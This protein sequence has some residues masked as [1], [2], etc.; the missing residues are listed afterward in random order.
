MPDTTHPSGEVSPDDCG[1]LIDFPRQD[2]SKPPPKYDNLP[3]QLTSFIGRE[4]EI[5]NLRKLLTTEARLVTLT[6][7]GGSGKTR[8]ALAVASDLVEGFEDGAWWVEL[9]SLS[10]QDLVAQAVASVLSVREVPGRSMSDALVEYLKEREVLLVLDNCEHLVASCAALCDTLL[11]AC[12]KLKILTTSREALRAPGEA[13]F[14]VPPLSLPDPHRPPDAEGLPGYEATRLF[15]ERARAAR[16]DFSLT[17]ENATAVAQ[18]CHRLDGIPLAIEL[19]AFRTRVLSV[20]QISKRLA[21]SFELL[22]GGSRTTMAH[23]MTLRATMDWSHAL[24]SE[25]ERRLF[26]RLSAFAGGCTLSAAEAICAE[27]LL[28]RE[29]ILDLLTQ[30]VDKS[31]VLVLAERDGE[32][33]YE[34]LETLRQYGR[35]KLEGSGEARG[36]RARHAAW[37]LA[38]AE[39]AEPHLRGRRQ[40]EWLG[41]LETEHDNLRAAMRFLL[42]EGEIE[43]SVRLAWALWFFWYVRGHQ[44]EGY[45]YA[46]EVLERRDGLP[47]LARA[48]TLM[49]GAITSYGLEDL[50][51]N[52][53]LWEQSV[54]LFR[55]AGN[56]DLGLADMLAGVGAAALQRGDAGR[57][58]AAFEEALGLYRG[59]GSRWGAGAMLTQLGMIPFAADDHE[60]AVRHFEEGLVLSREVGDR[61]T[62]HMALCGLALS[63]RIRGERGRAALLYAEALAL[64]AEAGDRADAAHC[65]E[66]LAGLIAEG[67]DPERAARLF[68]ASEALLETAGA[69][70]YA[71]AQERAI[72]EEAFEALRSGLGEETFEALRTAGRRMTPELA[73]EYALESPPERASRPAYPAGL[74]VREVEVLRLLTRG[75]TNARIAEELFISPNTV[76]RHLNS[77]YRKIGASSRA[78]ATR[79]ASEHNLL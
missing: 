26:G 29:E 4:R 59:A 37:F 65:V 13:I 48:R 46:R 2:R 22:T 32:A 36:V 27:G 21:E 17:E 7:P 9:A 50:E 40:L 20:E 78:A 64:A 10:D 19:A 35:E 34:M 77:V 76:N 51:N 12:A 70:H 11:R 25:K 54:G 31:L 14:A 23:H 74:S 28:G 56:D 63:S 67:G 55:R 61:L 71:P 68:G 49:V 52:E 60:R 53:R 18:I 66:G 5:A 38:L 57:A 39:E 72:H 45:R 15:A 3:L 6:G 79:F 24:L 58:G 30:L 69:S 42:G 73:V 16:H 47:V 75:M 43:A 62:G 1:Q 41:R 44:G 33:R 8:L